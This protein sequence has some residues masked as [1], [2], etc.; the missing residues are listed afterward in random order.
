MIIELTID[1]ETSEVDI[2]LELDSF[3]LRESVRLEEALPADQFAAIM[4]APGELVPTPRMLQAM[5][6]SKLA[7]RFP[8]LALDGFDLDLTELM[9]AI[10]DLAPSVVLPMT[11]TTGDVI[12]AEVE[13]RS[14]LG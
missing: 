2:D 6:W 9:D 11:T 12:E 5:I 3:S 7:T 1:G 14:G 13:V 8:G 10:G 4:D